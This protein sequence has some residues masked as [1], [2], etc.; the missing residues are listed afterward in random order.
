MSAVSFSNVLGNV[1]ATASAQPETGAG[2]WRNSFDITDLRSKVG[3]RLGDGSVKQGRAVIKAIREAAFDW[4]D[5]G[6]PSEDGSPVKQPKMTWELVRTLIAVLSFTDFKTGECIATYKMIARK[7]GC[8]TKTAMRRMAVLRQNFWIDWVRRSTVGGP[9]ERAHQCANGYL[10]EISRLPQKVQDHIRRVLDFQNITLKSQ[11]DRKGSGPV[12]SKIA[13]MA[14]RVAKGFSRCVDRVRGDERRATMQAE[15]DFIR[16]ETE[17]LGEL[18]THKWA[19]VRHPNDP[20]AQEA[21]N[22]RM[23]IAPLDFETDK[24]SYDTG[25]QEIG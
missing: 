3:N 9:G 22:R 5:K 11:P 19:E 7:A 6:K 25:N 1:I 18:P 13:R 24:C 4:L 21:Y 10:F 23:G 15:A 17:L 14:E 12:P 8:C 16:S 20:A 2:V